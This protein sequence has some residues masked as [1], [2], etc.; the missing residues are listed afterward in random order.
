M[1]E[2]ST[3][4]LGEITKKFKAVNKDVIT[5]LEE[6]GEHIKS[7][8]SSI[9]EDQAAM[10]V[11]IITRETEV[12]SGELND[13]RNSAVKAVKEKEENAKREAEEKE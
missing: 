9:T 11:D 12:S 2:S 1:A 10:V 13:M 8:N 7:A 5:Q 3:T 6:Y 4:K